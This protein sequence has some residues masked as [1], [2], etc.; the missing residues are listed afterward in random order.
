MSWVI[1]SMAIRAFC[2]ASEICSLARTALPVIVSA[3][4]P[5]NTITEVTEFE[6]PHL[7]SA[8]P[9]WERVADHALEWALEHATAER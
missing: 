4:I 9:G 5:A 6:G 3:A 8:A 7:L 1:I 2:W